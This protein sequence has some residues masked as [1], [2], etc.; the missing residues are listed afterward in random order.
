MSNPFLFTDEHEEFQRTVRGLAQS[1]FAASYLEQSKSD[2]FPVDDLRRLGQAGILG[3]LVDVDDGG[4]GADPITLGI[5]VEEAAHAS[6][7][8]GYLVFGSTVACHVVA[9]QASPEAKKRWLPGMLAGDLVC[10]LALTEPGSGSDAAAMRTTA[11]RAEGGWILTGEKTS[12]TLAVHA[13]V[14]IVFAK[15]DPAAGAR[16]VTAFLVDTDDPTVTSHPFDDPGAK[17]LGRGSVVLNE[18]FVPDDHVLGAPGNGFRIVM[19][20]FDLTRTLIGLILVGGAQC[21]LDMTATY[22]TQREAF[23][24]T[25]SHFQ[26]VSFPIAEHTTYVEALRSLAYRSLGLRAAGRPHSREAAMVKWWGPEVAF[27]TMKDCI[28]LHGH[29]AYSDELPLQAMLRDVTGYFIGDGT[30]QIQKLV[31]ARDVLGRDAVDS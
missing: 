11:T 6:L 22:V 19:H 31:I 8:A 29:V 23:G 28:V 21:A 26:G 16:G 12:V 18:T 25:I 5:A 2:K 3:L 7:T 27:N 15:T 10:A 20:E 4:Q 9:E 13:H 1:H 17:P 24:Q 30:P 14:D